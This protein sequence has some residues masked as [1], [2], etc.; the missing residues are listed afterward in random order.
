MRIQD[1]H[2]EPQVRVLYSRWGR[3]PL[4]ET[5]LLGSITAG[6]LLWRLGERPLLDWDEAL[7][8]QVA[9]EI[10]E[11][12]NWVDLSW[13]HQPYFKKPPFLFWTLALSYRIFGISEWATR[14]PS[15]LFGFGSVLLV[16]LLGRQL[17]GRLAGLCAGVLLLTLYPFLTHGSRQSATDS[18]LLFFSLLALFCFWCGR[19][20]SCWL[21]GVGIAVGA[22]LLTKGV[23]ALLPV[24]I[25]L[26]FCS[27]IG[28][29]QVLRSPFFR[30]GL[31]SGLICAL[32]WYL[33][34]G[35]T[36]G[37]AFVR[38]FVWDETLTRLVTTYD[39]PVRPWGFYL[40]TLWGDLFHCRPLLLGLPML[41]FW[42][43][44]KTWHSLSPRLR[45]LLCWLVVALL[46]V[47]ST[48]TR[49][50]WYLLPVYPP[51]CVLVAGM[52]VSLSRRL[53]VSATP[54]H[55][56]ELVLQRTAFVAIVC[57]FLFLLPGYVRQLLPG[58]VWMEEFSH[59][60]N[61]LLQDIGTL[62]DPTVPFYAIGPQMSGVVFYGQRPTVFLA[63]ADDA[64]LQ[65]DL[66]PAYVLVPASVAN[67]MGEGRFSLL[68]QHGEWS[69]FARSPVVQASTEEDEPTQQEEGTDAL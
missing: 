59:D 52:G 21:I 10:V 2:E 30:L 26:L 54:H 55:A 5:F 13:N 35:V 36:H 40:E 43:R 20:H 7:Y 37:M 16:S 62:L 42:C 19:R 64:V 69:L 38:T 3:T 47:L 33:Y 39:A 17:Y 31:A 41:Y 51:L 68:R 45:F 53:F 29:L 60:R 48:Q 9:R 61:T 23:A 65:T 58:L 66:T 11:G 44:W 56:L 67:R 27:W 63:D 24:L 34:Q 46:V 22:G 28:K 57:W 25:M 8:A 32:P 12:G 18:P 50:A 6:V 49:H 4:L 14:F 1:V 15:V